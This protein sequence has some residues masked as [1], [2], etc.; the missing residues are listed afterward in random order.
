M[1]STTTVEDTGKKTETV[2]TTGHKKTRV[3]ACLI[4]KADGTKLP[5]FIVFTGEKRETAA[6]DK[7]I[8]NCCIASSPNACPV[9]NYMFKVNN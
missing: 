8:K 6:S 7:E 1:V 9:G 4:A 2:K 5:P 3:S